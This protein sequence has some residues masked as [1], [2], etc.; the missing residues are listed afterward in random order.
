MLVWW[1]EK[2]TEITQNV[3]IAEAHFIKELVEKFQVKILLSTDWLN[4]LLLT[5]FGQSGA[6]CQWPGAR[7][8]G[9]GLAPPATRG[10]LR[11]CSDHWSRC[12]EEGGECWSFLRIWRSSDSPGKLKSLI[13]IMSESSEIFDVFNL[14][15]CKMWI[16]HKFQYSNLKERTIWVADVRHLYLRRRIFCLSVSRLSHTLWNGFP[17]NAPKRWTWAKR[18]IGLTLFSYPEGMFAGQKMYFTYK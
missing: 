8:R 16:S 1:T 18:I 13:V 9:W 3:H 5:W 17:W 10:S 15:E 7:E 2:T 11:W 4:S 14:V 6:L 12:G